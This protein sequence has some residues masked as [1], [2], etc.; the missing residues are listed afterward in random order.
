MTDLHWPT[1]SIIPARPTGDRPQPLTR[2]LC[3][4]TSTDET[5]AAQRFQDRYGQPPDQILDFK[6][7]L[8]V[9]PIPEQVT[10]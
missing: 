6:G 8:W 1:P 5:E 2:Y 3:F 10:Q 4:T 7:L 9:G